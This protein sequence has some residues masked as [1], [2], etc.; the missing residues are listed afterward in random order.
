MALLWAHI[1]AIYLLLRAPILPDDIALK[2]WTLTTGA[3][4]VLPDMSSKLD[5]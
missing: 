1:A 3:K 4:A 5:A 2:R